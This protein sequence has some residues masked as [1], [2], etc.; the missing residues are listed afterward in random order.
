MTL[1]VLVQALPVL[2]SD[3]SST[4]RALLGVEWCWELGSARSPLILVPDVLCDLA[5]ITLSP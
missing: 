4:A 2:A 1:L 5:Q 3:D